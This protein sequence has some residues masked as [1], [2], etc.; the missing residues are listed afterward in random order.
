MENSTEGPQ[1]NKNRTTLWSSNSTSGNISKENKTT[2][3]K[4]YLHPHVHSGIIY[5]SQDREATQALTDDEWIKMLWC[6]HTHKGVL[7][8]HQ[9]R[10]TNKEILSYFDNMDGP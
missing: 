7:F 1:E 9:N 4:N 10:Q 3:L 2:N 8:S 6:A 5:D